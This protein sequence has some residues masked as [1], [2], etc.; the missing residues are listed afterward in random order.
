MAKSLGIETKDKTEK[1]LKDEISDK[2]KS[3]Q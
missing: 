1:Q 3:G 2:L